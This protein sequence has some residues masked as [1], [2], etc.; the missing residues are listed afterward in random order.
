MRRIDLFRV[1]AARFL[2]RVGSEAAFFVGVWGKAA[3]ELDASAV[4]LA[5]L[6]FALTIASL[7]GSAVAGVLVDRHGPR[8]VLAVA[9]VAFVPTALAFIWA[10]S[11]ATLT[12]IAGLWAFVGTPVV[13]AGESF[14]PYLTKR[15]EELK[16]INSMLNGAGSL[17]FVLGPALGALVVRYASID[18]V[19]VLDAATSLA[20]AII[21][22]RA[23]L[24]RTP[25]PRDE[26][27]DHALAE[28]VAGMR[29]AYR[30][31]ALRY[32]IIAG[33]LAWVSFSAFGALEPLFFRD[34]V[35]SD[36]ETLGWVNTVFGLGML[37]GAALLPRMR[38]GV[39]SARGLAVTVVLSGF[40]SILYVGTS[41]LRVVYLGALTWGTVIGVLEPLLR[42]LIHRDSPPEAVGR[43][44]GTAE[45]HRR[46]GELL[47]LAFAPV[48]AAWIGVQWTMIA[49]AL[50]ASFAML[51]SFGEASA[52]DRLLGERPVPE[53]EIAP[54]TAA[55]EPVSP[56]K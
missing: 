50:F 37:M 5:I 1:V 25:A 46:A 42:T 39:L 20:A 29:V 11:M 41:D 2:S 49:G 34:I 18:W 35:R 52:I 40:G 54:I 3:F 24:V 56:L 8:V 48:I 16:R 51:L 33:T 12:A 28:M 7:L 32:Y 13:T 30:V 36:V 19:F 21:V 17:S 6:M 53:E 45:V 27:S 26:H 9:E 55:E 31:R 23:R 10:D 47:P 4:D 43:V 38:A 15:P 44:I 22:W 14:A